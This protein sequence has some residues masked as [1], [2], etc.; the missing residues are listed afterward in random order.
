MLSFGKLQV[1]DTRET[2]ISKTKVIGTHARHTHT[3][4]FKAVFLEILARRVTLCGLAL[5][6]LVLHCDL[7]LPLL[8]FILELSLFT[9]K[10]RFIGHDS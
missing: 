6:I 9:L 7:F 1:S 3:H 10:K 2:L 5:L 4:R 8:L